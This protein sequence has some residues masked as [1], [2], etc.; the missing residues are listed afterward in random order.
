MIVYETTRKNIQR[1]LRVDLA[2]IENH[3]RK[4]ISIL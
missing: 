4:T 1:V 3:D 2:L